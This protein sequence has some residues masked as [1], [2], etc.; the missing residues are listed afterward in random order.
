MEELGAF[1][2][3]E[4]VL[5]PSVA[6]ARLTTYLEDNGHVAFVLSDMDLRTNYIT[7]TALEV[8]GARTG[9]TLRLEMDVIPV[10]EH[11]KYFWCRAKTDY[12]SEDLGHLSLAALIST[13]D[14]QD[15]VVREGL[16]EE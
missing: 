7:G 10:E 12:T 5:T 2:M 8:T 1:S 3:G 11:P 13:P 9:E 14:C 16:S 6:S 15:F 4:D